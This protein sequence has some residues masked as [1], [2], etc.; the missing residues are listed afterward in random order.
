MD[1]RNRTGAADANQVG[2]P[3]G[4]TAQMDER[5]RLREQTARNVAGLEHEQRGEA[6]LIE[7]VELSG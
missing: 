4:E 5:E 7:I 2:E 1:E 3:P 6:A